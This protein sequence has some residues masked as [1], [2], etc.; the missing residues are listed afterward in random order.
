MPT[1]SPGVS[2]AEQL[3]TYQLLSKIMP[4]GTTIKYGQG[5]CI[6]LFVCNV[7]E[8]KYV[9]MDPFKMNEVLRKDTAAYKSKLMRNIQEMHGGVY[10][11]RGRNVPEEDYT[12]TC[13]SEWET[14]FRFGGILMSAPPTN[15]SSGD[16]AYTRL[17]TMAIGGRAPL[18]NVFGE[19]RPNDHV[20][21]ILTKKTNSKQYTVPDSPD[22]FVPLQLVP[23]V[24]RY[25]RKP[26]AESSWE[27]ILE[28]L[29][30]VDGPNNLEFCISSMRILL[31]LPKACF[32]NHITFDTKKTFRVYS[33]KNNYKPPR[34]LA[35]RDVIYKQ[36][37]VDGKPEWRQCCVYEIGHYMQVGRVK[38]TNGSMPTGSEVEHA[39]SVVSDVEHARLRLKGTLDVMADYR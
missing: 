5:D 31:G 2:G 7:R 3:A 33:K 25:S 10:R 8:G 17:F 1:K 32:M 11:K 35:Y 19:A 27:P 39:L 24:C 28:T 30:A 9:T 36:V 15:L 6:F 21:F 14:K 22:D 29:N 18:F 26:F 38:R 12:A 16:D 20:G 13:P 34:D 37:V 4:D 23:A